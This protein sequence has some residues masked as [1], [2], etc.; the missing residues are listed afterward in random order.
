M[1]LFHLFAR[2]RSFFLFSGRALS[3]L[4]LPLFFLIPFHFPPLLFFLFLSTLLFYLHPTL[5]RAL[6]FFSVPFSPL[7]FVSPLCP[8]FPA[9]D[10]ASRRVTTPYHPLACRE[11]C[12]ASSSRP[13]VLIYTVQREAKISLI[14]WRAFSIDGLAFVE[15]LRGPTS[16]IPKIFSVYLTPSRE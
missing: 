5:S 11:Y 14:P 13:K 7:F 10:K 15:T 16:A 6:F 1:L 8:A 3:L 12:F 9:N 2:S 4:P